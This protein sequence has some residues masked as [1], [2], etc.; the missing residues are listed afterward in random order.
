MHLFYSDVNDAFEGMVR[1]F[2]DQGFYDLRV[3]NTFENRTNA[4]RPSDAPLRRTQS[5][6]GPVIAIGEPVTITYLHPRNRVLFNKGR[7]ANPFLH[8]IEALW[9]LAGRNDVEPL[10]YYAKQM[11]EYSDDGESFHGA[12]GNRWRYWAVP[13]LEDTE[14]VNAKE[15]SGLRHT[16]RP[17]DQ[18]RSAIK[19]LGS[20]KGTRRVVLAMWNAVDLA[21]VEA[22]PGCK[23]VPCNTQVM[24]EVIDDSDG[25][26]WGPNA[27][28]DK[29]K[30]EPIQKPYLEMTVTNRS[31]DMI[32]GAL[33]SNYVTFSVLQEYIALAL[34]VDVGPYHQFSKNMHVY[35]EADGKEMLDIQGT[36][37]VVKVD[38]N[39]K[40]S[41]SLSNL[42]N[43][44]RLLEDICNYYSTPEPHLRTLPLYQDKEYFDKD[45]KHLFSVHPVEAYQL[46]F[47]TEF[48]QHVVSP[49]L[50]AWQCHKLRK[51]D[52][53]LQ[54][55]S[56]I[57]AWDWCLA[58][59][60]WIT[61][62]QRN[63]ERAYAGGRVY[64]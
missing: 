27:P 29:A 5:R 20:Q 49:M 1:G 35:V 15:R 58:A 8:L 60:Q 23:D 4:K 41:K 25:L 52:A 45:C 46:P 53:A 50:M 48:F 47:T 2:A 55:C 40:V 31:N 54:H 61:R 6:N 14:D 44:S 63:Y 36:E 39:A 64:T 34:G 7:D 42:F 43:P 51:Y 16:V 57:R 26:V 24:L 28:A 30:G 59:G 12:Y 32:W 38:A 37:E 33:G 9:M 56:Q 13:V 62:R 3:P 10:A 22:E 11:R 17:F 21:R 19:I 18:L